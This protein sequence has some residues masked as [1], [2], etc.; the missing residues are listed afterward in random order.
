MK[1]LL[2]DKKKI[3][4]NV[5]TFYFEPEDPINWQAG[6][7]LRYSLQDPKPDERGNNRFFTIASAPFEKIIQLTTRLDPVK[8][9]TFK[10]NLVGMK[11]GDTIEA[12]G[13]MGSFVLDG[14]N[15]KYVFVAGGI[16]ITPF[17]SIIKQLDKN[18]LPI[19]ISLIYSS[20][21]QNIIFKEDFDQI[22]K[23]HPGFRIDYVTSPRIIDKKVLKPLA[24]S[25]NQPDYFYLSGPQ[26][27][28]KSIEEQLAE[29]R[30]KKEKIKLDYFPGYQV[31]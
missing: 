16:G 24:N 11:I 31:I 9:S 1:L 13:P 15:K 25:Q 26:P 5:F 7:F 19:H 10:K 2:K 17:R 14:P 3:L 20:R 12:T 27:M 18:N 8:G 22:A 4:E 21:D 23:K 28:V 6:Q 30:V 29:L